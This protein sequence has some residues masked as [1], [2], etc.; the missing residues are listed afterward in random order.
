MHIYIYTCMD[1]H[2]FFSVAHSARSQGAREPWSQGAREP[3]CQGNQGARKPGSQVK[4]SCS[5]SVSLEA[6]VEATN[7]VGYLTEPVKK[8]TREPG[9]EG[10]REPGSQDSGIERAKQRN[11]SK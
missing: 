9:S 2:G 11:W 4:Q 7:F 1:W 10:A 5:A 6:E 8:K 3:G